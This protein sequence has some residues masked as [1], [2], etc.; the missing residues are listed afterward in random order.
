M[1]SKDDPNHE[2]EV[3][4]QEVESQPELVDIADV[5]KFLKVR[6]KPI[7]ET[8]NAAM[9]G[10]EVLKDFI[11]H[12]AQQAI[13]S[14]LTDSLSRHSMSYSR[15]SEGVLGIGR[16][17]QELTPSIDSSASKAILQMQEAITSI[18]SSASKAILNSTSYKAMCGNLAAQEFAW[19]DPGYLFKSSALLESRIDS[20]RSAC[21]GIYR[22]LAKDINTLAGVNRLQAVWDI[23]GLREDYFQDSYLKAIQTISEGLFPHRDF[24]FESV[25]RSIEYQSESLMKAAQL[26]SQGIIKNFLSGTDTALYQR[27]STLQTD[28][29]Q[30]S[31]A[32]FMQQWAWLV[33]EAK[34]V[35]V[36]IEHDGDH[37]LYAEYD[38]ETVV[39]L[40][41]A[42]LALEETQPEVSIGSSGEL[43]QPHDLFNCSGEHSGHSAHYHGETIL[44][45]KDK[46][47]KKKALLQCLNELR[48]K[49][50]FDEETWDQLETDARRAERFTREIFADIMHI[51]MLYA[52]ELSIHYV[53]ENP[54]SA[55]EFRAHQEKAFARIRELLPKP[56][57]GRPKGTGLFRDTDDFQAALKDVLE[58]AHKRPSQRQ[59]LHAIRQHP[60]CRKQTKA[61]PT[62][63]QAKTLR[64]WLDKC[65]MTYEDALEKYW[66]PAQRG[67]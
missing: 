12:S 57:D 38:R 18:D 22:N 45:S 49:D 16:M 53:K 21:D 52:M 27:Y 24:M 37:F 4:N 61:Y 66:K 59:A 14:G 20:C 17:A 50:E 35:S 63:N 65:G 56:D 8:Y 29:L 46:E 13:S 34:L 15:L 26:A 19:K 11:S 32:P 58:N 62:P 43:E 54:L 44:D 6:A 41:T 7:T 55:E 30:N 9:L 3:E 28:L 25:R 40:L 1:T 42:R 23:P 67:K 10:A 51:G 60:L 5:E 48:Q 39:E 36:D 47:S 31:V 33:C 2:D 64:N